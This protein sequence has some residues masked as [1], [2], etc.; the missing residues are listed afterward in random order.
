MHLGTD[1]NYEA[2]TLRNCDS[3]IDEG[4]VDC[5]RSV[6][7][8]I[9]RNVKMIGLYADNGIVIGALG[10]FVDE[11]LLI[12][13]VIPYLTGCPLTLKCMINQASIDDGY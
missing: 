7:S 13:R 5:N 8:I 12:E 2:R 9:V 1:V 10:N 6:V 3:E 11:R 4:G